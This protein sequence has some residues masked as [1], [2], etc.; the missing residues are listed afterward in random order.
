MSNTDYASLNALPL[1]EL[2][3][4]PFWT[5]INYF[6]AASTIRRQMIMQAIKAQGHVLA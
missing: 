1:A 2:H 4:V 6:E 3:R 5:L